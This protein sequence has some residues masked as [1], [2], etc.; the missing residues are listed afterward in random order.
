M[1]G[2]NHTGNI[3]S[4]GLIDLP[5]LYR[6]SDQKGCRKQEGWKPVKSRPF[7][8]NFGRSKRES[9]LIDRTA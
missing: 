6:G 7:F 9:F 2:G 1:S 5:A 8:L 3:Y 4:H